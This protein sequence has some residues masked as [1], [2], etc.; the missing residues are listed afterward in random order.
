[1]LEG[2]YGAWFAGQPGADAALNPVIAQWEPGE[3][4]LHYGKVAAAP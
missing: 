1:M 3:A 2:L 4:V